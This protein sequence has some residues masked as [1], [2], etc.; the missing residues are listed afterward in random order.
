MTMI[1]I[2]ATFVLT[3]EN[4]SGFLVGPLDP[5][6]RETIDYYMKRAGLYNSSDRDVM[7]AYKYHHP[8]LKITEIICYCFITVD[9][10]LRLV[11]CPSLYKYF[12]SPIHICEIIALVGDWLDLCIESS[13][14][15]LKSET[16]FYLNYSV[17]FLL[18]FQSIRLFRMARH[19]MAF[20]I[21]SLSVASSISEIGVLLSLLLILTT[22]FGWLMYLAEMNNDRFESMF[23]AMY[24]ALITLTTV[25]Y[26]DLFP[27]TIFGHVVA[28]TCA[29]CGIVI[30]ALPIGV[31]AA[32]FN[33]YYNYHKYVCKHITSHRSDKAD[34]MKV[35]ENEYTKHN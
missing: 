3:S 15:N 35:P 5:K 2:A 9:I 33:T 6:Q 14:E 16:G 24:W 7:N 27:D 22:M 26:G 12:S 25:G 20:N 4:A 32:N 34:V 1:V 10:T 29:V 21:M 8:A 28:C 11:T 17:K 13:L 23:A 19:I 30:L 18:I 31:I